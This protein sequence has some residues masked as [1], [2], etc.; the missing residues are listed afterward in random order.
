[1][2]YLLDT[3]ICIY[4]IK[5]KPEAVFQRFRRLSV[6][7][8]ALSTITY[9]ELWFGVQ[10]S[11][12]TAQNEIAL[13]QFT[14]PLKILP[15]PEDAS[16]VYGEIRAALERRGTPIGPLDTLIAAHARCL[17]LT[18]VTNNAAEFSRVPKLRVENWT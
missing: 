14:A 3:N 16:K 12:K 6:G 18:L 5:Q 4:I 9:S 13:Q 7:Q 1:M 10:K 11:K 15:Y 2:K 8:V 17:D